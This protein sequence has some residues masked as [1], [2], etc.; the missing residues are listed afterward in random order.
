M[1]RF[2]LGL[3]LLCCPLRI[4]LAQSESES[5]AE[6]VGKEPRPFIPQVAREA[7][8][9]GNAAFARKDYK[10][11]RQAYRVMLELAPDNLAG[12]VNLGMLEFAAGDFAAAKVALTRA[13]SLKL[14]SAPAWL[15]LGVMDMEQGHLD[16]A[17]AELAQATLYDPGNAR[18]RNYF[19]VVMGRKGWMDGAQDELRKAVEID[20]E[21]SDA[22]Y[23]LA[24]S[25]LE[26]DPP[27]I[28]LARRHYYRAAEL[29]AEP[30]PEVE[31][32]LKAAPAPESGET[33]PAKKK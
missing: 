28:E 1:V 16:A 2:L 13:V 18:A 29:G 6:P 7:A 4:A 12:L 19:G 8:A 5:V 17:L 9:A 22:H 11:A 32:I 20:P 30:D 33:P 27:A 23:N 25:Y 21:F 24:M 15:T 31:K 10:E 26:N 3:A 14:D